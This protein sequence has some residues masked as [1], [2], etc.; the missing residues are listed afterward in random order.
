VRTKLVGRILLEDE[1][2][3]KLFLIPSKKS[4][5]I[6]FVA[7]WLA[8]W[9]VA[10]YHLVTSAWRS[11][12]NPATA[13]WFNAL[14]GIAWVFGIVFAL[15]T[16]LWGFGGQEKLRVT[17]AEVEL[18]RSLFGLVFRRRVTPTIEIR[19]L[20]YTPEISGHRRHRPGCIS[21]EDRQ[22]TVTFGKPLS[23]G[24]GLAV[25]EQM[26]L[27]HPFPKRDRALEYI[28]MSS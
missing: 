5:E 18:T 28:D 4:W 15:G 16:L 23:E 13:D 21:F 27:V 10:P 12:S 17:M 11:L 7:V 19:N 26:L 9:L 3:G 20:R 1:P 24:E 2:A 22:G 25:I 8:F 6:P 14:W